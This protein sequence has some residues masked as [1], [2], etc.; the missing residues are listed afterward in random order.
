MQRARLVVLVLLAA[1]TLAPPRASAMAIWTGGASP[2]GL[3]T[4]MTSWEPWSL[5][6]LWFGGSRI[7]DRGSADPNGGNQA[8]PAAASQPKAGARQPYGL[9]GSRV[10]CRL[11]ADPLGGCLP[12]LPGAPRPQVGG[13]EPGPSIAPGTDQGRHRT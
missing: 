9:G 11:S 3:I 1:A 7:D 2:S 5:L 4:A 8:T 13:R 6:R 10:D 12:D